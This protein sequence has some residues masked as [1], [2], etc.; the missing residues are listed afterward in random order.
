MKTDK[1]RIFYLQL[2]QHIHLLVPIA[3]RQ[4]VFDKGRRLTRQDSQWTVPVNNKVSNFKKML[5]LWHCFW[6]SVF[7]H[8]IMERMSLD[9][10]TLD[11][12]SEILVGMAW[13]CGWIL[14]SW[15]NFSKVTFTCEW[16]GWLTGGHCVQ[17]NFLNP[18]T[19]SALD[20]PSSKKSWM[21]SW[22]GMFR[23]LFPEST[24]GR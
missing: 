13:T 15:W 19:A 7:S 3:V 9:N 21:T 23:A 22:E 12:H 1:M 17:E 5:S 18:F 8:L 14:E 16:C 24:F 20:F 11:S 4:G 10:G 2:W 6:R